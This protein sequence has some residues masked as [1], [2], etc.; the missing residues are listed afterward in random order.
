MKLHDYFERIE[1]LNLPNRT[2][3]KKAIIQELNSI[4]C[5]VD[6]SK[7][8]FFPAIRPQLPDGFSSIGA[9]GCF[10]S[11]YEVLKRAYQ[12]GIQ[13]F[14]LL[15]DD[16]QLAPQF[17]EL[18]EKVISLLQSQ[19]WDIVYLGHFLPRDQLKEDLVQ[20]FNQQIQCAHFVGFQGET[21]G[22]VAAFLESLLKRPAGDPKGG[23]MHVDGAYS[24]FRMVHPEVKTLVLNPSLGWQRSSRSDIAPNA[25]YDAT[26]GIKQIVS[27][28]RSQR[29]KNR[30]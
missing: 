2:D 9:R 21:I 17:K 11:H 18:E 26:P 1:I 24:T 16:L 8:R 22:Q 25:W 3:R 27:F 4:G 20:P 5:P 10:L 23:P 15:E 29:F 13:R 6:H 7:V 28:L 30:G 19:P 12:D 14:L